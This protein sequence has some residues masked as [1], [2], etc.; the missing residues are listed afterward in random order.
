MHQLHLLMSLIE[1]YPLAIYILDGHNQWPL[2]IACNQETAAT[3]LESIQCL[4]NAWPESINI[5]CK[6]IHPTA[7]KGLPLDILCAS[8]QQPLAELICVLTNGVPPLHFA[9]MQACTCWIPD[10]MATLEKLVSVFDKD[11]N[12][13]HDGKT[14]FHCL[15]YA[16][17]PQAVLK[18][19]L[20]HYPDAINTLTTDT[21]DSP[22]HCCLSSQT[23]ATD[24]MPAEDIASDYL[25]AVK[26][27]V[28]Q[29]PSALCHANQMG[30][31]PLHVSAMHNVPLELL[32][33]L[34][35]QNPGAI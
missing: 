30:F 34:M 12:Q 22:L 21:S 8:N 16:Q 31:L 13:F 35:Q 19:W 11:A 29:Q 1:A 3:S 25:S 2:H 14:P 6:T 24:Y 4:V 32:F 17:A 23:I 15:C 20:Q 9:C 5:C 26:Y 10:R 27:L 28:E 7:K 33:Y 18:W